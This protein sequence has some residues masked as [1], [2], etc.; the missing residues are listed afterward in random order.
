MRNA[1]VTDAKQA[2]SPFGYLVPALASF[3]QAAP[4][5][6]ASSAAALRRRFERG[7]YPQRFLVQITP[8]KKGV[9]LHAL[10]AWIRQGRP[11]A[12]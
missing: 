4:H 5:L 3:N 2:G 7:I 9:D 6:G 12:E 10:I 11:S 1:A 8:E